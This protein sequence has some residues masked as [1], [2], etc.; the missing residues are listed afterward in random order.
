[1]LHAEDDAWNTAKKEE[2]DVQ[3]SGQSGLTADMTRLWRKRENTWPLLILIAIT[4]LAWAYTIRQ[5]SVMMMWRLGFGVVVVPQRVARNV[6]AHA[7][8]IPTR[9]DGKEERSD[10]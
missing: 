9:I 7:T 5:T 1:M 10:L 2:A 4:T 8:L 3:H 6:A